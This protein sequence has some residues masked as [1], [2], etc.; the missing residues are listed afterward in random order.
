MSDTTVETVIGDQSDIAI[1]TTNIEA[2]A[3]VSRGIDVVAI[4]HRV[5]PTLVRIPAGLHRRDTSIALNL[6]LSG[7]TTAFMCVTVTMA[8]AAACV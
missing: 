2:I 6:Q 7:S 8:G 4:R 5:D 3:P 1:Y